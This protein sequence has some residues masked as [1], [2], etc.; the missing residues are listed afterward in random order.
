MTDGGIFRQMI[1]DNDGLT[2]AF[3][4]PRQGNTIVPRHVCRFDIGGDLGKPFF[5]TA[6]GTLQLFLKKN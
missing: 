6:V 5:N 1:C 4:F 3:L 2:S